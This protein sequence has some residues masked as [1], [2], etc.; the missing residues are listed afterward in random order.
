MLQKNVLQLLNTERERERETKFL[1]HWKCE[2]TWTV[3]FPVFSIAAAYDHRRAGYLSPGELSSL[4]LSLLKFCNYLADFGDFDTFLVVLFFFF[5]WLCRIHRTPAE[6]RDLPTESCWR[7]GSGNRT[8][9]KPVVCWAS[10]WRRNEVSQIWTP[11]RLRGRSREVL[12]SFRRNELILF[13]LRILKT[14]GFF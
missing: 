5:F 10:S 9:L 13:F 3:I 12:I 11:I 1:S 4:L 7:N 8:F 6:V 14:L 2:E